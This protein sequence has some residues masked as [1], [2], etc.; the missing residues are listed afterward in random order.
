[1]HVP[2]SLERFIVPRAPFVTLSVL[3]GKGSG[4]CVREQG[5]VG[6]YPVP[7]GTVG[8]ASFPLPFQAPGPLSWQT[9]GRCWALVSLSDTEHAVCFAL[10]ALT[11]FQT[12][13]PLDLLQWV[14]TYFS[15]AES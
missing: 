2:L 10:E 13:L 6:F 1:M 4:S 5:N 12:Q 7:T 8:P 15:C 14:H 3:V 9:R 11:A